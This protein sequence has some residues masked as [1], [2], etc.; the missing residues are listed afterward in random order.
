MGTF[1]NVLSILPQNILMSNARLKAGVLTDSPSWTGNLCRSSRATTSL[2]AALWWM[3]I[4]TQMDYLLTGWL[5]WASTYKGGGGEDKIHATLFR[6][7]LKKI[8]L[9]IFLPLQNYVPL[10]GAYYVK[11]QVDALKFVVI[12]RQ[13]V[14]K[15]KGHD[16]V[17]RVRPLFRFSEQLKDAVKT[18]KLFSFSASQ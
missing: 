2:L 10:S 15:F 17:C 3:L 11:S 8:K 9:R 1:N 12:V 18:M 7:L 13:I 16:Y 5:L 4:N 14:K 6:F